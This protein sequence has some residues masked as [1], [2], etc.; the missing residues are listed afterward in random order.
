VVSCSLCWR[1]DSRHNTVIAWTDG[2]S[3]SAC[4]SGGH[5][6]RYSRVFQLFEYVFE[7]VFGLCDVL[8]VVQPTSAADASFTTLSNVVLGSNV[9][10]DGSNGTSLTVT[11][12]GRISVRQ[13]STIQSQQIK[14]SS[15]A[16]V[17]FVVIGVRHEFDVLV[18]LSDARGFVVD[19]WFECCR[20]SNDPTAK[21][22]AV[23]DDVRA[24]QRHNDR[25]DVK[26]AHINDNVADDD[27]DGEHA[28]AYAWCELVWIRW[29]QFRARCARFMRAVVISFVRFRWV[30]H[31]RGPRRAA[32]T[33]SN[34]QFC[35][36]SM[37]AV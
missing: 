7:F 9:L 19:R 28:Y 36:S 8:L 5:I 16:M 27:D 3:T 2:D 23:C 37:T 15:N 34:W 13:N 12:S 35:T 10:F 20:R 17:R 22:D 4:I 30:A 26:H 14:L 29:Q 32:G 25:T 6:I 21:H 31:V 33:K 1:V 24:G 18:S 11:S